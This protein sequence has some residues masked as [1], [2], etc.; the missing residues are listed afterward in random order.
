MCRRENPT[1]INNKWNSR[2]KLVSRILDIMR[3]ISNWRGPWD[4]TSCVGL[5]WPSSSDPGLLFFVVLFSDGRF[6]HS[7]SAVG[8]SS[9]LATLLVLLLVQLDGTGGVTHAGG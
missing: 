4:H 6:L 1:N 8:L 9:G 5:A 3:F 2:V 7:A